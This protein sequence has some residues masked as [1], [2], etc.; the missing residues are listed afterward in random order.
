MSPTSDISYLVR[1][2]DSDHAS[3]SE[4]VL[5]DP[6]ESTEFGCMV[7]VV[8]GSNGN[9]L[10][11]QS[12]PVLADGTPDQDED[13]ELMWSPVQEAGPRFIRWV[14]DQFNTSFEPNLDDD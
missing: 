14:N 4:P 8:P 5:D 1:S 2:E 12:C 9:R 13:G 3:T 11:I 7:R 10:Y 6:R